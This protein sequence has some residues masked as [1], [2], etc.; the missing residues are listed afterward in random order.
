MSKDT[1]KF[2][3]PAGTAL[4]VID[5]ITFIEINPKPGKG[6]SP[7]VTLIHT[8]YGESIECT[9]KTKTVIKRY[10]GT[11]EDEEASSS[12]KPAKEKAPK[13]VKKEKAPKKEKKK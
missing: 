8:R 3:T 2:K 6:D 11:T 7:V 1:M 4:I 5:E 10:L 9:E 13:K 12:G